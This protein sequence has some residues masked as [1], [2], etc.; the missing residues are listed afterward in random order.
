ME[1]DLLWL[2][3]KGQCRSA[4]GLS[5]NGFVVTTFHLVDIFSRDLKLWQVPFL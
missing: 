5:A 3:I 1:G 2:D 4:N